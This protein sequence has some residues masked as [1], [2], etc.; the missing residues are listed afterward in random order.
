MGDNNDSIDNK[1]PSENKNQK[2]DLKSGNNNIFGSKDPKL[3]NTPKP[4]FNIYWIYG[5]IILG[6]ISLNIFFSGKHIEEISWNQFENDMLKTHD[7]ERITVVNNERAEIYIKQECLTSPKYKKYF[8]KGWSSISKTG[9]HFTFSIASVDI[10]W[11]QLEEAQ[12]D[13]PENERIT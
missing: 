6:F 10:F 12:K 7:V 11:K 2:P 9:P 4:K 3:G 1:E 5:L 8:D 13:F